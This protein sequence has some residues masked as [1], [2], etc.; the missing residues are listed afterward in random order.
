MRLLN[1]TVKN[2]GLYRGVHHFDL[3]ATRPTLSFKNLI[4]VKGHNGAGKST[5]FQAIPLA[6][7]GPLALGVR[8]SRQ[9]YETYLLRMLH[10]HHQ[11]ECL[12]AAVSVSFE[13]VRSGKT[14][15]IKV[16]RYWEKNGK[17]AFESLTITQDG[18]QLPLKPEDYQSWLNELFPPGIS[19]LCFFDAERLEE[20]S[21]PEQ[22]NQRL[23]ERVRRLLGLDLVERLQADL[24]QFT[25]HQGGAGKAERLRSEVLKFQKTVEVL[26]IQMAGLEEKSKAL[27]AEQSKAAK[28]LAEQREHLQAVGGGYAERKEKL[29]SRWSAIEKEISEIHQQVH[30]LCAGLGAFTVAPR[31]L[32][33]VRESLRREV[34]IQRRRAAGDLWQT[35]FEA[36]KQAFQN[37]EIWSTIKGVNARQQE[38]ITGQFLSLLEKHTALEPSENEPLLHNLSEPDNLHLQEWIQQA[39]ATVPSQT[40]GL[41]SRLCAL[42]EEEKTIKHDLQ[43]VPDET[44]LA[45]IQEKI[46]DIETTLTDIQRRKNHISEEIGGVRFRLEDQNRK[47]QKASEQLFEFQ[48]NEHRLVLAKRSQMVLKTYQDAL[49]RQRLTALETAL[50]DNFN[51]LCRKETLL[52]A[53]SIDPETFTVQLQNAN[54]TVMGLEELSAGERQLYALALFWALR[55]VSRHDLPLLIDTPLARLDET[56]R[57][58]VIQDYIPNVSRQVI[59]FATEAEMDQ[60][61]EMLLDHQA[62]Q[63]YQLRFDPEAQETMVVQ[64]TAA[65]GKAAV[66]VP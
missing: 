48:T 27:D 49:T 25:I 55:Q 29:Q 6:L 32:A 39:L 31:L 15:R 62:A 56:H 51:A 36:L 40:Q 14:Q 43:R 66:Y 38:I 5:L 37:S 53:L 16:E 44:T 58:R 11:T 54:N 65:F 42:R 61:S 2:F 52:T 23:A 4:L 8:L 30:D 63:C 41:N 19:T 24:E 59:L 18:N 21:N 26:E 12:E 20:F 35:Q 13:Y 60:N 64:P 10:R 1:L 50:L 47:R 57:S 22:H 45:P 9:Q 28:I 46:R 17:K 7:H 3:T 34:A 33:A